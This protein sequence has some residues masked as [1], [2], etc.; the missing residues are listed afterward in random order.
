MKPDRTAGARQ[1]QR[2]LSDHEQEARSREHDI[3]DMY[4]TLQSKR[5]GSNHYVENRL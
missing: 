2:P 5:R 1:A 3:A 4:I